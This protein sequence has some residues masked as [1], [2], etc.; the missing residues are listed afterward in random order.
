[1]EQIHDTEALLLKCS[2]RVKVV[3]VPTGPKAAVRDTSWSELDH[4]TQVRT[5]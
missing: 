3:V 2:L 4:N 1:M 5:F